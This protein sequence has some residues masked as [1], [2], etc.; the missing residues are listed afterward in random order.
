M[1]GKTDVGGWAA[2]DR[3]GAESP[4]TFPAGTV[5]QVSLHAQGRCSAFLIL[6]SKLRI[7]DIKIYVDL[8]SKIDT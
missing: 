3:V 5:F 2:R 8:L 4:E 1:S 7:Y 6:N